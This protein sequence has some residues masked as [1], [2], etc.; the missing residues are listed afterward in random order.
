ML[1]PHG[2]TLVHVPTTF[3]PEP[4]QF[5]HRPPDEDRIVGNDRH[6]QPVEPVEYSAITYAVTSIGGSQ[7]RNFIGGVLPP[8]ANRF[9]EP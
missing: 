1:K 3:L 6:D 4:Q 9:V 5:H 2:Y 7:A 8:V